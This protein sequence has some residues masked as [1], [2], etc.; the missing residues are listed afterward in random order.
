MTTSSGDGENSLQHRTF[1]TYRRDTWDNE[2]FPV[3]TRASETSDVYYLLS[4]EA[5]R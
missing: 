4:R 5:K 2:T 3:K 1:I